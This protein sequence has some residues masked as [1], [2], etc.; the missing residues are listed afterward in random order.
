MKK[1]IAREFLFILSSAIA[2]CLIYSALY[3]TNEQLYK[4]S[5]QEHENLKVAYSDSL[6]AAIDNLKA[7]SNTYSKNE[8]YR[9]EP[10]YTVVFYTEELLDDFLSG[11]EPERFTFANW[12]SRISANTHYQK[13][14]YETYVAPIQKQSLS[15]YE[16]QSQVFSD[17]AIEDL[18]DLKEIQDVTRFQQEQQLINARYITYPIDTK[19]WFRSAVIAVLSMVFGVRYLFYCARWSVRTLKEY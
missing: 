2:L 16:W 15:F 11:D 5:L 18:M 14:W 8:N 13:G 1:F 17:S 6:N 10:Q 4:M 7:L 19:F 3:I 12:I 9:S